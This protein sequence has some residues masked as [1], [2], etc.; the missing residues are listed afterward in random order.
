MTSLPRALDTFLLDQVARMNSEKTIK[1]YSEKIDMWIGFAGNK[2]LEKIDIDDMREYIASLRERD[3]ARETIRSYITALK[4]VWSFWADEYGVE[5]VMS[6]IK[7]PKKQKQ[8]PKSI[9]TEDFINLFEVAKGHLAID[10]RNRAILALLADT[11][12]R[13]GEMVRLNTDI[14][15]IHRN[16]FVTGKTGSRTI[17]WSYYVNNLLFKWMAIRPKCKTDALFVSFTEGREHRRLTG[18]GVRQVLD[19]L[20][21]KAGIKGRVNPHSFRHKFAQEYIKGGGDAITLAHLGG[22]TDLRM[23]KEVYAVFDDKE[24]SELQQKNSPILKMLSE[25]K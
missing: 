1:D 19:R 11:G 16:A 3:L 20:K 21:A 5:N 14:D 9:K 22:W 10:W 12:V 13:R 4:V 23:I 15:I 8:S 6:R 24:L 2:Q 25:E 17:Y 7:K 18:S